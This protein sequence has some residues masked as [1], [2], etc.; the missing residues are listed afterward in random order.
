MVGDKPTA[1]L[2]MIAQ[3]AKRLVETHT[4]GGSAAASVA[5][6]LSCSAGAVRSAIETATKLEA[7]PA[8]NAPSERDHVH[9]HAQGGVDGELVGVGP[10]F[11]ETRVRG[12]S[13]WPGR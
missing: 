8:S 4:G 2:G 3:V 10:E 12:F 11:A 6:T 1:N 5:R 13:P 9:G 7:L